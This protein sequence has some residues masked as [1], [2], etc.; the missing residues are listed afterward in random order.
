MRYRIVSTGQEI[1][2][3]ADFMEA[4]HAGDYQ[5]LAESPIVIRL[6]NISALAFIRRFSEDEW[7]GFDVASI[8]DPAAGAAVRRAK[9]KLRRFLTKLL[10]RKLV[11]LDDADLADDLAKLV[12]VGLLAANRPAELLADGTEAEA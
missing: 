2:A 8:D 9:A 6:R 11:N 4:H 5:E 3:T 7:A 12:A 10:L 1:L